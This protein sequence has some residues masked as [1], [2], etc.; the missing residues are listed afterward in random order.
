MFRARTLFTLAALAATLAA[1][2]FRPVVKAATLIFPGKNHFGVVCNYG[3]SRAAVDDLLRALPEGATLTVID[4]HD[5]SQA[6]S[7]G[8]MAQMKGVELLALL[9][10][11]P[12]VRD[13]SPFATGVVRYLQ[14]AIPAFGTTPAA[15][16]NGC[17]LALGEAT[18]WE[19]LL[20]PALVDPS[21]KG[22]IGPIE[23]TKAP[24]A[25]TFARPR[26]ELV[27][28]ATP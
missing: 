21:L 17:A 5:W 22:I 18:G 11:D 7:A 14:A 27:S 23:I 9:P 2:D 13:G 4:A 19:L 26:F 12:L 16:R 20:N 10:K 1:Q 28:L 15:L 24:K 3:R 6:F 25:A 8:N